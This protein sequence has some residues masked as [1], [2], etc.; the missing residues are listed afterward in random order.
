ML[1]NAVLRWLNAL[2]S[3]LGFATAPPSFLLEAIEQAKCLV[4]PV[5]VCDLLNHYSGTSF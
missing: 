1:N 3:P 4:E 5:R 2:W